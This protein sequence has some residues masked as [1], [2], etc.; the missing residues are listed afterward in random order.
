MEINADVIDDL[1]NYMFEPI[2]YIFVSN[3]SI[4]S[5]HKAQDI[6]LT[7]TVSDM[8]NRRGIFKN[9]EFVYMNFTFDIAD[10][11]YIDIRDRMIHNP[12]A[13]RNPIFSK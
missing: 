4:H 11:I 3:Y 13:S 5:Q 7:Q 9:V 8:F 6:V 1:K 12:H 10:F 2:I